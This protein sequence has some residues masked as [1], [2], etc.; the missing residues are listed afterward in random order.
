MRIAVVALLLAAVLSGCADGGSDAPVADA[1]R[2]E[3]ITSDTGGIRG[4]VVDLSITPVLGAVVSLSKE[5]TTKTDD[6]GQF[7]FTG[8]KPGQYFLRV[9]KPGF[10]SSQASTEV[11]AGVAEPPV[12]RIQVARI[13]GADPFAQSIKFEGFYECAFGAPFIV[14]QC[15]F[16]VRTAY[17]EFNGTVPGYP[18]PRNVQAGQNTQFLFV[19]SDVQTI[20]QEAYWDD[21]AVTAMMITVSHTP[22]D[23]AC[24]C[25]D[26]WLGVDEMGNPTF[27]RL[28][29]ASAD[30]AAFP[31]N[32]DVAVRGFLPF[33]DPQVVQNFRFTIVT[34]LFYNYNPPEGW[35]FATKDDYPL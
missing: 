20:I 3:N 26:D 1:D 4:V 23:N 5:K 24:D 7:N 35:T 6:N 19:S 22:I 29:K 8:L 11:V 13:P 30:D 33:G 28:D 32:V 9:E 15:D 12:V 18:L 31:S 16:V 10:E 17:D 2:L 25:S 27:A 21:P 34:S 14:D